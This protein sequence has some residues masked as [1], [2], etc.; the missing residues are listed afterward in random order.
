MP[1]CKIDIGFAPADCFD[2]GVGGV[3]GNM[4]LINYDDWKTAT[5]TR[6]VDGTITDVVLTTVGAAAFKY[7]LTR[8]GSVPATPFTKNNGGKS[9]FA[10]AVV[11]FIPSRL[12]AIKAEFAKLANFNRVIA[13]LVMDSNVAV[14]EVYGDES[15]LELTAFDE[16]PGDPAKGGGIQPTLGTPTDTTLETLPP[17][18]F[19]DGARATTIAKLELLLIPV[20]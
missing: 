12:Q 10:H 2:L 15:G 19:T 4:Y 20:V 7:E 9:G 14:S 5:I 1:D 16:T 13:I 18:N 3:T 6:D 8:G 17:V 11:S